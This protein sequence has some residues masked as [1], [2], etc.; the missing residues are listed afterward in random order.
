M[1]GSVIDHDPM[2]KGGIPGNS[3]SEQYIRTVSEEIEIGKP[4]GG[5]LPARGLEKN[6]ITGLISMHV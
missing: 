4:Y 5:V 1:F 6:T 2:L 3:W